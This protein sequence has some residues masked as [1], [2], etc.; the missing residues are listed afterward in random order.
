MAAPSS[1]HTMPSAIT[2]TTPASQP[3]IDCGPPSALM[4]SGIVMN[5][6]TPIMLDMFSAMAC[7]NPKRRTNDVSAAGGSWAMGIPARL[8]QASFLRNHGSL[9]GQ[10]SM[11]PRN[12]SNL[13]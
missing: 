2:M 13:S 11:P 9:P 1:L 8:A 6:P 4:R 3:S 10:G 7:S 12:A 5:G